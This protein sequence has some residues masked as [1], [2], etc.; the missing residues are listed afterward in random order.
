MFKKSLQQSRM[1]FFW[2]SAMINTRTTMKSKYKKDKYKCPHCDDG[3]E[4]G[5]LDTSKVRHLMPIY[6]ISIP[7]VS[8]GLETPSHLLVSCAAYSA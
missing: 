4:Q 3:S 2:E 6:L 8:T 1:E 7:S 5:V